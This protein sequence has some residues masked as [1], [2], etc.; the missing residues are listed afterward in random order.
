VLDALPAGTVRVELED[1]DSATVAA[2]LR[3]NGGADLDGVISLLALAGGGSAQ[4]LLVGTTAVVQGLADSGSAARL[5]CLTRGAVSV[6]ADDGPPNPDQAAL[7]GFG[8]VVALEQ[9]GL[10]GGL[11]DL[12]DA[13]PAVNT[14]I[15]DVLSGSGEEDQLAV[16]A[17][18]IFGR[19]LA[20]A[21]AARVASPQEPYAPTGTVLVTGGTGALGGHVARWLAANG[22]RNLVLTGRRGED[23]P[24]TAALVAELGALG[25]QVTVAACDVADRDALAEVLA[26]IP[27]TAPLSAVFH[28]AGVVDDGVVEALTPDRFAATLRPKAD[29]VRHLHEL[30]LGA[31]LQAFVLFSSVAGVIG[32]AGQGNYAAANAYLDAF[33][34]VRLAQGL[35]AT[36][37]AWGPWAGEGMAA[38]TDTGAERMRRVGMHPLASAPALEILGSAISAGESGLAVVDVEWERFAPAAFAARPAPLLS[39]LPRPHRAAPELL[40]MTPTQADGLRARL[41]DLEPERRNRHLLDLVR[42]QA[43]HVLGHGEAAAV[44]A[45]LPFRDLG[46]DSLTTLELRNGLAA[47]TGLRLPATLLFDHPSPRELAAHLRAELSDDTES[48]STQTTAISV[49][50][51]QETADDPIA[52]VGMSCRFPGGI[53]SPADLWQLLADG[54]DAIGDFPADRGWDLGDLAGRCAARAGGFLTGA[55]EFDA[56]FFGISPREALVMDPQQRLLLETSWE[57]LEHAGMDPLSLRASATGVF[58]GTNG[59]DYVSALRRAA[60]SAPSKDPA[61]ALGAGHVATGNTASVMSGRIAYTLGLEGPAVTVDTACSASLVALHMASRALRGGECSLALAGGV[62][63]MS[64]PDAFVEFSLQGGLAVDGRCKA[65][66]AGADGTSWSE[67]AGLLV[68]ERLSDAQ[69]NGHRVLALLRGSAVN[70][71]GASNGLTAPNGSAQQRVIRAALADAGMMRASDI[72][73]VEAHGTGTALGDPIEANA[74][75]S[76]YGQDRDEP[77]LLGSIKSNLGH[78]QGAA[79]V[80]GVI[81]MVL[82]AQHGMLPQ[83]LHADEASPHVDWSTGAVELLTAARDWPRNGRPRRAGVSAFGISGTNAHVIIEEAPASPVPETPL[84]ERSLAPVPWLVSARSAAALDAQIDRLTAY[85]AARPELSATA[86]GRTLAL[87]RAALPHRAVLINQGTDDRPELVRG[88]VDGGDLAILFTGQG[89][90]RLGMGRELYVGYPRFAEA[91]DEVLA[92]LEPGLLDVMWG[93][94]PEPLTDTGNAQQALFAFEVALFRLAESWGIRPAAVA[95][96]SIGELAAAHVAGVLSLP[97]ACALVRARARLMAALPSGGAMVAVRATEAEVAAVLSEQVVLAA[98]NGPTSVVLAGPEGPVLAAAARLAENGSRTRRLRVSHAFHSPLMDPMLD[99]F[100]RV[101]E[102]LEYR[103]PRIPVVSNVTGAMAGPE[104]LCTPDYWVRH[105]R[106]TVRFGDGVGALAETGIGTYLELGPAGVLSA[107]VAECVPDG[108]AAVPALRDSQPEAAS[109]TGALARLH[110]RGVGINWRA[111]WFGDAGPSDVDL[112]TYAFQRARYWPD[113]ARTSGPADWFYRTTWTPVPETAPA[114]DGTTWLAILGDGDAPSWTNDASVTTLAAGADLSDRI[115]ELTALQEQEP[116]YAGVLAAGIEDAADLLATLDQAEVRAPLWLITTTAVA[117]DEKD[118]A[119]DP[120]QAAIWGQGLACALEHPARWGGLVD[121]PADAS[122]SATDVLK[123]VHAAGTLGEDQLAIRPTGLFARRLARTGVDPEAAW[124]PSGTILVAGS[125]EAAGEPLLRWLAESARV[126]LATGPDTVTSL[127]D[128]LTAVVVAGVDQG[129]VSAAL[130]LDEAL[131]DRPLEALVLSGSVSGTW[132][133]AG[134]GT[135]AANAAALDAL[136][137]RRRRRGLPATSVAWGPWEGADTSAAHL[138]V[139]GLNPMPADQALTALSRAV[140]AGPPSLV[141]ADVAWD[142]FAPAHTANRPG[143]L[144][145][146]VPEAQAALAAAER[147]RRDDASLANALRERLRALREA[148][149]LGAVTDLVREHVARVLGH[150]TGVAAIEADRAFKDLGFDSLTAVDLRGQLAGTTGLTT[151][152]VTLAFD[153]ATP[154]ALAAHLLDLLLPAEDAAEAELRELLA[155]IPLDRLR[156]LG[157][158]GPLL[159]LVGRTDPAAS[160]PGSDATGPEGASP[161]LDSMSVEDLVQAAING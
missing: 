82:A 75:L 4:D 92:H 35:P 121:L 100:R 5:W 116:A 81:K 114:D 9:P 135:E 10:W 2:H 24:G 34:E 55:G 74:L 108:A 42:T 40:P 30:T 89:S 12:C 139:N 47:A 8:R 83:T 112:P 49:R 93:D 117:T 59:Q 99:E 140:A 78:T 67:G 77:L 159:G 90:Q 11:I 86:V 14:L 45:D 41:A 161:D 126:V 148:D 95:G 15:N 60:D 65:F 69:R 1:L 127:A 3:E 37:I 17:T 107:M 32:T 53:A 129:A 72:D 118:W 70:A 58:I 151:L 152:P 132:G 63:V 160:A 19:R 39:T 146:G 149:R 28:A 101:A 6:T 109:L 104:D 96:H 44:D 141:I 50:T 137:E 33:A 76:V 133:S 66:G 13:E 56:D 124:I 156:E 113:P 16:R 131:G 147:D 87:G 51:R 22:A 144:L 91:L 158:L 120:N 31:D 134:R 36:A 46:F 38:A 157:V 136:A 138:R 94:D 103:S 125:A 57:A 115:A 88:V 85:T 52:I 143:K 21:A 110:V 25:T 26:A 64:T 111:A 29:G 73:V 23:A 130:A 105:V 27:A 84:A 155:A 61:A 79:G 48:A 80:A 97:D 98:V 106:E 54:R 18:G 119:P 128:D 20:H 154:E 122:I 102:Q 68:L 43:A 62:S 153:Y 145:T 71:D 142:R 150:N 7:W 123:A